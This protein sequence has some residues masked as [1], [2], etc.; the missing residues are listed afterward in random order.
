MTLPLNSI[1]SHSSPFA[2]FVLSVYATQN[3]N[4]PKMEEAQW[5]ERRDRCMHVLLYRTLGY[6][7]RK[8]RDG[9]KAEWK[10]KMERGSDV[11]EDARVKT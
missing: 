4:S 6:C 11:D 3:H 2:P 9:E 5:K 8:K 7:S 1:E 10:R